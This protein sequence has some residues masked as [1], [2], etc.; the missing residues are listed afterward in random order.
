MK[1]LLLLTVVI[2]SVSSLAFAQY[3]PGSIDV[4]TDA[5]QGSCNFVDAGGLV[6]VHFFHT[7]TTGATAAQFMLEVP[8]TWSHLGDLW[9][10]ATSIGTSVVGVSLGYG[11]CS[12]QSADFNLGSANFFGGSVGACELI[13]IVPD[14]TA[15]T[16]LV[17]LVDCLKPP[18]GPNKFT[19]TKGGQGRVNNDGTCSCTVAVHETT[20]GGIKALYD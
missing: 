16:G 6:T 9:N 1:R 3:Q 11:V 2:L 18:D 12:G 14:P 8:A 7:H 4:Y 10:T 13:S 17:E 20:W 15:P 19:L 5:G